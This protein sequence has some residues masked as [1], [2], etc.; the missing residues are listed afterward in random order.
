MTD[1]IALDEFVRR[2]RHLWCWLEVR[3]YENATDL[4]VR[5]EWRNSPTLFGQATQDQRFIDYCEEQDSEEACEKCGGAG[6]LWADE[7]DYFEGNPSFDDT[8]YTCDGCT[9]VR[10]SKETGW[11]HLPS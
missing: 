9:R 1:T 6:W 10:P 11:R 7:L 4:V 3:G 5:E 8:K 2:V